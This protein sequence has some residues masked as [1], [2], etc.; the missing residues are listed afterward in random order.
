MFWHRQSTLGL[1]HRAAHEQSKLA[2]VQLS[3]II[4]ILSSKLAVD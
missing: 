1:L 3:I 4:T 2:A